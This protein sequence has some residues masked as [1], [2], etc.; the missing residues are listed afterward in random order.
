M[1]T[2]DELSDDP[3]TPQ[4]TVYG[5]SDNGAT[6]FGQVYGRT[7]GTERPARWDGGVKTILATMDLGIPGYP[8]YGYPR[9]CSAD[10]QTIV[11]RPASGYGAGYWTGGGTTPHVLSPAP[12]GIQASWSG[13]TRYRA[14]SADGSILVGVSAGSQGT[15]WTNGVPTALP[16]TGYEYSTLES[17]SS[18]GSTIIGQGVSRQY[19]I[20]GSK[21]GYWRTANPTVWR[22]IRGSDGYLRTVNANGTVI[23]WE[24]YSTPIGYFDDLN[25]ATAVITGGNLYGTFHPV[26]L[27]PGGTNQQPLYYA[28]DTFSPNPVSLGNVSVS[29]LTRAVRMIGTT[30]VLLPIPAGGGGYAYAGGLS[31]NGQIAYGL[32]DTPTGFAPCYWDASDT[33]H[34]LPM[35]AGWTITSGW[36]GTQSISRDGSLIWAPIY[37]SFFTPD[38][39]A[40]PIALR[41]VALE[42]QDLPA[43]TYSIYNEYGND[44]PA[45]FGQFSLSV[46]CCEDVTL[47]WPNTGSVLGR[48][49]M[50]PGSLHA[51]FHDLGGVTLFTGTFSSPGPQQ[52][53]YHIGFAIDTVGQ[54]VTCWGN[55][56]QWTSTDATFH[57]SGQIGNIP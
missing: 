30:S 24:N 36:Q 31:G 4:S 11:G 27:V 38:P 34:I 19:S 7:S 26:V 44:F 9:Q 35:P 52:K 51:E 16:N 39:P 17:M 3:N 21:I 14:I 1:A 48:L 57:T 41:L 25:T 42:P 37:R 47:Q 8:S 28:E 40:A 12:G 13:D 2:L 22:P 55:N 43:N 56:T 6:M 15:F 49:T 5:A 46:W 50:S 32:I 29:G 54:S 23:W 20:V 53:L 10:G 33:I 45:S 18:D